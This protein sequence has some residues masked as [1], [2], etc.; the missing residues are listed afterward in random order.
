MK[1]MDM[2]F[3]DHPTTGKRGVSN[4]L[5]FTNFCRNVS[6]YMGLQR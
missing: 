3:M 5:M 4:T 6:I 1:I 2:Y